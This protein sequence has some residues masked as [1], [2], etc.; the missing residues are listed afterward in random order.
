MHEVLRGHRCVGEISPITTGALAGGILSTGVNCRSCPW[1]RANRA[2]DRNAPECAGP[3]GEPFP[4]VHSWPSL[5]PDPLAGIRG[6]SPWLSIWWAAK[7]DRDDLLP[8]LLERLVRRGMSVIGGPGIDAPM[9]DRS[10]GRSLAVPGHHR[11]RR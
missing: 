4:A 2:A 10:P 7:T 3:P 6:K 11:L 1:C 9:A 8:Q 5:A